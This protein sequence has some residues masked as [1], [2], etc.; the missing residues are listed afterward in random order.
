[1]RVA[2][3]AASGNMRAVTEVAD[4]TEGKVRTELRG[5]DDE[6]LPSLDIR[7]PAS[8]DD[9]LRVLVERVRTRIALKNSQALAKTRGSLQISVGP[10]ISA[11]E[12]PR[13]EGE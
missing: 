8:V 12:L 6:E 3:A 9:T 2:T 7:N 4:R 5:T 13:E 10:M 11:G 1:M